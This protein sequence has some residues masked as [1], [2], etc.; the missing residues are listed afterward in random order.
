[1]LLRCVRVRCACRYRN[2]QLDSAAG[3]AQP[4]ACLAQLVG[5]TSQEVLMCHALCVCVSM[6]GGDDRKGGAGELGKCFM[7]CDDAHDCKMLLHVPKALQ[8]EGGLDVKEW[9]ETMINDPAVCG[10]L[11][12]VGEE[13]IKAIAKTNTEKQLFPL[14]QRDSAINASFAM[15]RSKNLVMEDVRHLSAP[16]SA[17]FNH[18]SY[19][20]SM[21]AFR[22]QV[23]SFVRIS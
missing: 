19:Y 16:L 4:Y 3:A 17:P 20:Y 8:G 9:A 18:M 7:S 13:T 2:A 15:L 22:L 1:M 21:G 14:K 5:I 11:V 23:C 12:E 6:S 10:E